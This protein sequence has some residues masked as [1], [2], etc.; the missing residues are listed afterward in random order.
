MI[1]RIIDI[2]KDKNILI[3]GF[4]REGKT[5]YNFIREYLPNKNFLGIYMTSAL[6]Y[7]YN[8]INLSSKRN[9]ELRSPE[10]TCL[11]GILLECSGSVLPKKTIS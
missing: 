2:I 6:N 8:Y 3:L 5:T 11:I 7:K 9:T 10:A 4:G 1:N